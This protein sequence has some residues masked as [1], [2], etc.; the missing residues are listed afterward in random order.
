MNT[1]VDA[2]EI[3]AIAPD[4]NPDGLESGV[5]ELDWIADV[6]VGL[7]VEAD[8]DE[9]LDA[10]LVVLTK[11]LLCHTSMNIGARASIV[12]K[13]EAGTVMENALDDDSMQVA[14]RKLLEVTARLHV[15]N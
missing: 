12:D 10:K 1:V 11:S 4:D 13:A 5:V 7:V 2:T 14:T 8:V 9:V 15:C 3:P 6:G